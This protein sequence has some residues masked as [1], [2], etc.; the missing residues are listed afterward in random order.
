M[1]LA[2]EIFR[3]L[4]KKEISPRQAQETTSVDAAN[5]LQEYPWRPFIPV[6]AQISNYMEFRGSNQQVEPDSSVGRILSVWLHKNHQI[7]EMNASDF[8]F[9]DWAA[10][11]LIQIEQHELASKILKHMRGYP[12]LDLNFI[13]KAYR[14]QEL[15]ALETRR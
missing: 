13:K 14:I 2:E 10:R 9:L 5:N 8:A 11:I 7:S 1:S 15:D 12:N 3:S 6:T 4:S